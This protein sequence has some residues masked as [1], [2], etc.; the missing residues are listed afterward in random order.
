MVTTAL[1]MMTFLGG[2]FLFFI[3]GVMYDG[4][5]LPARLGPILLILIGGVMLVF[6]LGSMILVPIYYLLAGIASIRGIQGHSFRYPI[7][8]KIIERRTQR[9]QTSEAVP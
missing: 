4:G 7:L 1:Y 8:G 3:V 6:G 9:S 2:F 5:D